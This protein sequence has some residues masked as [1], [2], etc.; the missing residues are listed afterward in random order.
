M[1]S[2]WRGFQASGVIRYQVPF[3]AADGGVHWRL[4]EEFD[5]AD[6]VVDGLTDDY[7]A[8][9]VTEFLATGQGTQGMVG[10]VPSVLVDAAPITAFAVT[11]LETRAR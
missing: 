6:P 5:T 8:T 10:A 11:W 2:T 1:P 9:I 4:V 7:F 3:A